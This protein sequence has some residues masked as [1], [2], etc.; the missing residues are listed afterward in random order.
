VI[1]AN[2]YKQIMPNYVEEPEVFMKSL[3]ADSDI[4]EKVLEFKEE[5]YYVT[6]TS[7]DK[8]YILRPEL[9]ASVARIYNEKNW[10]FELPKKVWYHGALFRH[11]KPQKGR[12]RQFYQLGIENIGGKAI[13]SDIEALLTGIQVLNSI[14][15]GKL[16]FQVCCCLARLR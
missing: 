12:L 15:D 9:T 8:K 7:G 10:S 16:K 4:V 5:M 6:S 13:E 2:A 3:G 14:S 1:E 11:E